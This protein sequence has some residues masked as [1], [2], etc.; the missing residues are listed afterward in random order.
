MAP[1]SECF[2]WAWLPGQADPVPAGVLKERSGG[3]WF[4]Y[5]RG[6][7]ARP[8]AISLYSPVL[9][10]ERR[11]FG[12][13][14]PDIPMPG[15]IR[16]ASPDAWGRRVVADRLVGTRGP[17]ADLD[18]LGELSYLM[19]SAS[20]RFGG[21]DFQA[22]PERYEARSATA[23]LDE[24]RQAAEL[25]ERG[26]P[27]A[28]ELQAA[29]LHGTSLGGARPKASVE[30]ET[31]CWLAKFQS[32]S[33]TR[34][35]VGAEAAATFLAREAGISVPELR[36]ERSGSKDVL[37]TRRFDREP[38]GA[39]IMAVSG[40]TI[41][42]L[43]ELEARYGTY[44]ELLDRLRSLGTG[45]DPGPE[46]FARIVFNVAVG[47]SD[48]HLRN[49]AALWDGRSLRLSPAFDMS[50]GPRSGETSYQAIAYGRNGERESS[51]ARL[52]SVCGVYGL[53]Q[54]QARDSASRVVGVI[55]DHWDEAADFAR[56][57]QAERLAFWGTQILNPAASYRLQAPSRHVAQ[58]RDGRGRF[59]PKDSGV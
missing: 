53:T 9:P 12:P 23:T 51:F 22:S 33:D 52:E 56:L 4:R 3:L 11:W 40:L 55:E 24:L 44:P 42:G 10:L 16:D 18:A 49:H 57:T 45:A 46:L 48:D 6:Y 14:A 34:N 43:G 20:D 59:G 30:D 27:I 47:N 50:P 32:T 15:P 1:I 31:G 13:A 37:L 8:D 39:R 41:L 25:V 19:G 7:L 28:A 35:W 2:V 17:D 21:L 58:P 36:M 29:A 38:G 26:I 54:A 5:G